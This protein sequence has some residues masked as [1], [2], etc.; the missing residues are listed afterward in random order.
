MHFYA[1]IGILQKK[2]NCNQAHT[3][4]LVLI[5]V[6]HIIGGGEDI[7]SS[8]KIRLHKLSPLFEIFSKGEQRC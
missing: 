7:T 5:V 6:L 3:Q 1:G 8:V 2:S 4:R